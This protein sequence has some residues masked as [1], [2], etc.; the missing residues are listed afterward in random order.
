MRLRCEVEDGIDVM[1]LEAVHHLVRVGYIAMVEG[2][3]LLIIE[4]LRIVRRRTVVKLIEGNYVICVRVGQGEMPYQPT[5][6]VLELA[7]TSC[8]L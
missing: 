8:F 7:K 5:R 3:V 2:E 6:T 1:L 4:N